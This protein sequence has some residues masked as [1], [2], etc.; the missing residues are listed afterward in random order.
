[1]AHISACVFCLTL[2]ACDPEYGK[3]LDS[4]WRRIFHLDDRDGEY[5][6]FGY[7]VD[8]FG[9]ATFYDPPA[10]GDWTDSDRICATFSCLEV[11][12]DKLATLS[13]AD[14]LNADGFADVGQGGPITLD[15]NSKNTLS[16]KLLLPGLA[17]LLNITAGAD[18]SNG[19]KTTIS[20]GAAYKRSV[21]RDDL[22][23]FI[24]T[25]STNQTLKNDFAKWTPSIYSG[26]YRRREC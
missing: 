16:G 1:M 25:K 18:I 13:S 20:M 6:W 12:Q 5:R 4:A 9:V 2:S 10:G 22:Q 14:W 23:K 24:M 7:P 19:V 11:P 15:E 26:R 17:Q 8:N 21:K 3:T